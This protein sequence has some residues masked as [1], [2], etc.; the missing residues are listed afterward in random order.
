MRSAVV[1][2]IVVFV[3]GAV[4]LCGSVAIASTVGF[5]DDEG[6]FSPKARVNKM[7][8]TIVV[9]KLDADDKFRSVKIRFI[10]PGV[11]KPN[12][13]KG[14]FIQWEKS[15]NK[16]GR[17]WRLVSHRGFN[18]RSKVFTGS[19]VVSRSFLIIDKSR[20]SSLAQLP[21]N[22][23]VDIRLNGKPLEPEPKP[24]PAAA[25]KSRPA[26]DPVIAQPQ[27]V[28]R[29]TIQSKLQSPEVRKPA[30][31]VVPSIDRAAQ[32]ELE[33]KYHQ[34]AREV[35]RLERAV[36][37]TQRWFYWGPLL[38]LTLSILFSSV[39]LFLTFVRLSKTRGAHTVSLPR[40]KRVRFRPE[41]RFRKTG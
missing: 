11:D 26:V 21:W 25:P 10:F 8:S 3:A 13:M 14:L 17:Q 35:T 36:A 34:L 20:R 5:V 29:S 39:A 31:L 24:K 28:Q 37:V 12:S 18:R 4:G 2:I 33:A 15:P 40:Y 30:P 6:N 19:W 7:G 32:R 9:R 16:L 22:K 23:I 1:L 41:D 27:A 38:A